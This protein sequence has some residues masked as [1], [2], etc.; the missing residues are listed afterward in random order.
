MRVVPRVEDYPSRNAVKL[1]SG[2]FL[3]MQLP[4]NINFQEMEKKHV[5]NV[6]DSGAFCSSKM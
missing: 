6:N 1:Y 4:H 2:I 5:Q 3:W